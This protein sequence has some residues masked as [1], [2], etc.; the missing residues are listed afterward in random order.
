MRRKHLQTRRGRASLLF[1]H[2]VQSPVALGEAPWRTPVRAR[3]FSFPFNSPSVRGRPAR[4]AIR[5]IIRGKK[6][7]ISVLGSAE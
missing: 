4:S 3:A 1:V 2:P 7:R 5:V 6:K